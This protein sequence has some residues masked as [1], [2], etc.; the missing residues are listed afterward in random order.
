MGAFQI[1][2][3]PRI[4]RLRKSVICA[5]VLLLGCFFA[6][7]LYSSDRKKQAQPQPPE[8]SEA[9]PTDNVLARLP[10]NYAGVSFASDPPA[11]PDKPA[12]PTEKPVPPE[13]Q[14]MPK[15]VQPAMQSQGTPP[16]GRDT[17]KE[18]EEA[19]RRSPLTFNLAKRDQAQAASLPQA[20]A[21]GAPEQPGESLD[22]GLMQNMQQEKRL[23]TKP[24]EDDR[25]IYVP[26][27]LQTPISP[28]TVLAGT[29]IPAVM[30]TGISSDLPGQIIGQ[31]RENVYDSVTGR[32]LLIPQGTKII[33]RY[34]SVIAYGQDRVLIVWNRLIMPNGNSILL[35]SM[36][37]TDLQGRAGLKDQVNNH[38]G[39]LI[40]S[41]T[42]STLLSAGTTFSAGNPTN[43]QFRITNGIA[44]SAGSSIN[45]AGQQIVMKELNRQPTIEIRPGFTCNVMVN[46]DIILTLYGEK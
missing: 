20:A 21:Y 34:D 16:A 15:Q 14:S 43:D 3:I 6:Y 41:V 12:Q 30:L 40:L 28:Y 32:Y 39:R 26:H 1:R 7:A 10:S 35:D 4:T 22:Q 27:R 8:V 11:A 19:A 24:T 42:L 38:Y 37:G 46:K 13:M 45:Q 18:E 29:I 33:G 9:N 31:V 23:C 17:K 44:A 2:T 5:V 36:S 25:A